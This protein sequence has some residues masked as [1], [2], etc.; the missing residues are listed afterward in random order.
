MGARLP[1]AARYGGGLTLLTETGG[2]LVV[3]DGVQILVPDV[4]GGSIKHKDGGG[5]GGFLRLRATSLTIGQG[6]GTAKLSV[7]SN[8]ID[9]TESLFLT[10]EMTAT[11]SATQSI[12]GTGSTIAVNAWHVKVSANGVY[13]LTT[14]LAATA[15]GR[16][17]RIE[18][19]GANQITLQ[20]GFV[21]AAGAF[22]DVCYSTD[23]VAWLLAP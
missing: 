16:R 4:A 9:L 1:S 7:D 15:D 13:V 21:I 17:C 5:L 23:A 2:N 22:I 11:P 19:V 6:A 12:T 10:Q 18:N 20:E 3:A 14:A 8:S